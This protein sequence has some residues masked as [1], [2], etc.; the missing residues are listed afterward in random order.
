MK[1][2]LLRPLGM[3]RS[4]YLA[5]AGWEHRIARGHD[6]AGAPIVKGQPRG[7]DVARYGAVGGLNVTASDYAKFLIEVVA[8]K[9][10]RGP[11]QYRLGGAM[12]REMVRP[13]IALPKGGE[14]DGCNAWALG[15]ACRSVREGIC[16]CIREGKAGFVRWRWRRWRD[17]QD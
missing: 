4:G 11:D 8:P 15:W 7:S 12:L 3:A 6:G 16:W 17:G 5:D 13:Q 9:E 1:R 2:R 14:I 10:S